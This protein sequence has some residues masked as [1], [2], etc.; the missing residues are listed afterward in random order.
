MFSSRQRTHIGLVLCMTLVSCFAVSMVVNAQS[1]DELQGKIDQRTQD[2]K[3]LEK[4]IAEFQKQI[5]IFAG[6]AS[7]LSATIKSLDLTQKK[8]AADISLTE[9]KIAA[10]NSEIQGLSTE[11]RS[12]ENTIVDDRRIISSSLVT[13]N[14]FGD[15]S[16]PELLLATASLSKMWET[17][18]QLALLQ[19]NLVDRIRELEQVKVDLEV[20]K[21]STEKA[22]AEL[23]ELND[24]LKD[25]RKVVLA[26]SAEKSTLLKTTKQSETEYQRLLA[27]RKALK[28]AFEKEILNY[29][30]QLRLAVDAAK[31][32]GTGSGVLLWPVD[33]VY[34]TQYFGN[35]DFATANAQIYKGF[36]H[37][38]IDLRASIGTPIRASLSG[39]VVGVGN[40]DAVATCQSYGKWIMIKHPNG[41][42]TLYAHLSLH[43]VQKGEEVVTGQIIGYSGNTG[44]STGP[45]LHFGV[46]ATEGVQI[47]AFDSSINCKGVPIPLADFKAY[48]NP[49][50][51]LS[52]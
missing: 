37:T 25:Q 36:G 19:K 15:N 13:M 16:L 41:L 43:S 26:T 21:K 32:P 39:T 6:Q 5:D 3:N 20:S 47:K 35:T 23:I 8:L 42:S 31:L 1:A 18:E 45:H 10:K 49:L 27:Q 17:T 34:V 38:G 50:S 22:K 11:I 29:E 28:D 7:T 4:E 44:Y 33:N 30:S 24:Q 12:K 48:L 51:Y 46:Y 52:K 14:K 2:I 9:K 40:T